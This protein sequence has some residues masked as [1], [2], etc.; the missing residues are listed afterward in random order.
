MTVAVRYQS[1]KGNTRKIAQAIAEAIGVEALPITEPLD[2]P[3][4]LLFVG[5]ALYAG[6]IEPKLEEFLK[7]LP[8]DKIGKVAVF[9]TSVSPKTP[10]EQVK[11]ILEG[12]GIAI[13]GKSFHSPG[14]FLFFN[15]KRPNTQDC[16]QAAAFAKQITESMKEVM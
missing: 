3:V 2:G 11:G 6:G 7:Q 13:M 8:A 16:E 4:D 12:K 15:R 5:G 1:R 9:S 10:L 14:S